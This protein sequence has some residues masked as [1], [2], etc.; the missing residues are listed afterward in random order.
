[1]GRKS[2][3]KHDFLIFLTLFLL[4]DGI[5]FAQETQ[6]ITIDWADITEF[7]NSGGIQ[8]SRLLGNVK[9]RHEDAYMSCDSA[10]FFP[11]QNT[12]DAFS[13][14]H[15]WR[16]DTLDLYGDF[17]KYKGNVRVAEIRKNVTLDDKETHLTTENIDYDL[18]NDL[19]YYF[20]GGR[21]VNG[22]NTLVSDLG[23][24]Y[25]RE[26]L[27]FFKDSVIIT[28]PDYTM[29]SDTLKYNTVSKVA[30][31]LGPTDIISDENFIY[32]EN[33]W[34]DTDK[35]ISQFN[36]NAFLQNK[37]KILKGDSI[38]YER[39]TG[40]GKAFINVE[41]IDT[42]QKIVLMGNYA[43]YE[44]LS[45]YAM[46]TDSALMI[47]ID[48]TDSL[49]IHAD[50]LKTISDTIPEKK[51][52]QAYYH[53]K[54][55]RRDL[56]GKCDSLIY[57]EADSIFRFYGEPVLWSEENQLTADFIAIETRSSA[58]YK[59]VMKSAAFIISMEDTSRFNQIKGRDMQ[60]WFKD[61]QLYLID[62]NG[63][64]QTVYY[65]KDKGELQGVNKA[66]SATLKIYL[67]DKRIDKIN[68]ITK[69]DAT[70]YP[71]EKFPPAASKLENFRWF[72]EFRPTS[73]YDVFRW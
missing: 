19:G 42:A 41:L 66:E 70:Y 33:G 10:H 3:Y 28:N 39:E 17:L 40:L 56:Q 54:I 58:L 30:Y 61:N 21:I 18:N 55:Y 53:V 67:K 12:L 5:L 57:A 48:Q 46:L 8:R 25:T 20:K 71:L 23:Y 59:I 16:G 73:R 68:F 32:C 62:V 9:F 72:G 63:N 45:D 50:T 22:E 4:W 44:E 14:V 6:T 69:P 11:E 15:I 34:Y 51:L 60:G 65:A 52:I 43:I 49:F 47:Q 13:R 26:K 36:K 1:M 7:D 24:Y 35:N 37:E 31:F 2:S 64:G 38:Y 27:F 29:Y